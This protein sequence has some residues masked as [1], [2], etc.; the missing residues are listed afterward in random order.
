VVEFRHRSWWNDKAYRALE[1]VGA[2]FCST[3]GPRL[4]DE[5]VKTADDVYI[6]FHGTKRWYR[7]DYTKEELAV[8]T[9]R[10][11]RS[12]AKAVWAYFNNDREGYAIK[13]ARELMRQ[14]KAPA[15]P[16]SRA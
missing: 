1:D 13:N 4:P 8:W 9:Q 3:S 2:I 12:G 16:R 15:A 5:L 7:H 6:R 11:R 14:L 10:I